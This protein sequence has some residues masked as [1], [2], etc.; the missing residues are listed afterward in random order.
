MV[1]LRGELVLNSGMQVSPGGSQA[2]ARLV[3][4]GR[5][6]VQQG[7]PVMICVYIHILHVGTRRSSVNRQ[8]VHA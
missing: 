8:P 6:A 4:P 7:K 3:R 1:S 2:R 5:Q